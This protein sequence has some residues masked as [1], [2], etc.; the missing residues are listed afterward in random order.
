MCS[1]QS[2]NLP[3]ITVKPINVT[4]RV[5]QWTKFMCETDN[6]ED[7]IAWYMDTELITYNRGWREPSEGTLA[8]LPKSP[9]SDNGWYTCVASN[10]YGSANSS[11]YLNFIGIYL[12]QLLI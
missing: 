1:A 6:Y 2:C 12:H 7:E 8:L 10:R 5:S 4:L 3:H 11:A 9:T